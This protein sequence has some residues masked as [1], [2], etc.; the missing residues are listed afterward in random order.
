MME[1]PTYFNAWQGQEELPWVMCA[2]I[3]ETLIFNFYSV[4][5]EKLPGSDSDIQQNRAFLL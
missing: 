2:D 5:F 1:W 3:W 4:Y